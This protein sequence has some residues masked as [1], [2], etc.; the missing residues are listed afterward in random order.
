M[1]GGGVEPLNEY[2]SVIYYHEDRPRWCEIFKVAVPIDEF[3]GS[4][5]KFTYK[6]RSSNETKD[7]TEKPFAMSYVKLM[8]ANGTTLEDRQHDLLVFKVGARSQ[9]YHPVTSYRII[10][11]KL[12]LNNVT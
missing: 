10:L 7:K 9:G 4:H 1:L 2:R 5:L 11:S 12:M 3:K 6:H 8:Q